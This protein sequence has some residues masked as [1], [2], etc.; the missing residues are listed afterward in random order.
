VKA[1][2]YW[3]MASW[4]TMVAAEIDNFAFEKYTPGTR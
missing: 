1:E 3:L 2:N 4:M